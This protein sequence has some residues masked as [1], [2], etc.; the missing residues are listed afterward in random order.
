MKEQVFVSVVVH[1]RDAEKYI[2]SFLHI[3]NNFLSETFDSYE[4]ILVDNHST[5]QTRQ[6]IE[7]TME[8][9]SSNVVL[10]TLS[11]KHSNELVLMAGTD[12]AIGDFVYE[13]ESAFI[14]YPL[15]LF[16]DMYQKAISGFDITAATPKTSRRMSSRLFYRLLNHFSYLN[17]E[18]STETLR[19]VTRRALNAVL[20]SK[21]K[22]PYRK[23]LYKFSGFPST[24]IV[25]EP[26][27]DGEVH[28][29]KSLSEKIGLAF[30]ILISFSNIG[31]NFALFF[32]ALFLVFSILGGCYTIYIYFTLK[33]IVSGW[34]TL[35]LFLSIGF[36]G[37]FF[38][39]GM[40][41]KYLSVI[42]L[43]LFNRPN[44]TIES[45]QRFTKKE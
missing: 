22:I 31:P 6:T 23:A 9:I 26:K 32:S 18:L 30:D 24:T 13:L 1:I 34:T 45:I 44:Y 15:T 3:V 5:D 29:E 25:Y 36:S 28:I 8:K 7:K 4:I 40:I 11:W 39:L 17:F 42:L 37:I 2:S 21:E 10:L 33:N 27:T 19:L 43:E 16:W 14:D 12:I 20:R 35:M 41:G 38:V